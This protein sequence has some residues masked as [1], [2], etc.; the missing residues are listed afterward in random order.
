MDLTSLRAKFAHARSRFIRIAG[1]DLHVIDETGG[2]AAP[3]VMLLSS[4]WVNARSFARFAAVLTPQRRLIRV[5]LPGQGLTAPAPDGDHSAASYAALIAALVTELSLT[6][7]VIVGTSFSA[8]P[9][10]LYAATRPAG[11]AGLVLATAS[12]LPR[13]AEGP[14]PNMA[15]PDPR[16]AVKRDGR[17]PLEFYEWKLRSLLA[18]PLPDEELATHVQ[19]AAAMND[20][21]GRESELDRRVKAHDSEL[22]QRTLP[23]LRCPCLV[24]WSSDS[25][26][27]P[28]EM[29]AAIAELLP[30]R[31]AVHVYPRTGH[32]LLIDAPEEVAHDV[33]RF[34]MAVAG[35]STKTS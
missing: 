2:S 22:M 24:Q 27:L 14:S 26:Y 34:A 19:E 6:S 21:P 12:G 31:P 32:L 33:N 17:R 25:T 8:I 20:L 11:L 35:G 23:L 30:R 28:P 13:R 3:A 29:A 10:V 9:A 1:F 4:Q 16:L 5:D 7:F 15:P 18:R